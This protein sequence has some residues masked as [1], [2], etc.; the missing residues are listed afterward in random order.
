MIGA[1]SVGQL[2][3]WGHSRD[4][5]ALAW[6]Y[7][8][9]AWQA[10][11]K[12]LRCLDVR[13]LDGDLV[14]PTCLRMPSLI[15][16]TGHFMQLYYNPDAQGGYASQF[17]SG[18]KGFLQPR[19]DIQESIILRRFRVLPNDIREVVDAYFHREELENKVGRDVDDD[20]EM[21]IDM[22]AAVTVR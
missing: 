17:P 21:S 15:L 11:Q 14:V 22:E 20:Q 13:V 19:G 1:H 10:C 4:P 8:D 12:I 6:V 18:C 9:E 5:E 2:P 16:P 3:N 7:E